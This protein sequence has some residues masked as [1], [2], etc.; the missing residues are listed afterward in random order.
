MTRPSSEKFSALGSS[1]EPPVRAGQGV[2]E[3]IQQAG[4][5]ESWATMAGQRRPDRGKRVP[6][7]RFQWRGLPD[8]VES[9]VGDAT[10]IGIVPAPSSMNNAPSG[11]AELQKGGP[12]VFANSGAGA[13]A[14]YGQTRRAGQ[15]GQRNGIRGE[16]APSASIWALRRVS[17]CSHTRIQPHTL[18]IPGGRLQYL[19]F[20]PVR[21][22]QRKF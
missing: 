7:E 19:K 1:P 12:N 3:Y 9:I 18:Q 21:S 22:G 6:R 20:G 11:G 2:P 15:S 14:A 16:G 4:E 8:G 17:T 5:T 13:Y 10:Q